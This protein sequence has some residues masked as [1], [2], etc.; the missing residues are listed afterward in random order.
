MNFEHPPP[1]M[2]SPR[3]VAPS[4]TNTSASNATSMSVSDLVFAVESGQFDLNYTT[5]MG[6]TLFCRVCLN[7]NHKP[8]WSQQF[9]NISTFIWTRKTVF[10]Y[11]RNQQKGR[12]EQPRQNN[13][14]CQYR[15]NGSQSRNRSPST[16]Q[17]VTTSTDASYNKM[18]NNSYAVRSGSPQSSQT[19][20]KI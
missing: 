12:N 2:S 8:S 18:K 17:C 1:Q 20:S 10:A 6:S 15:R 3:H 4:S 11:W 14:Y 7:D 9:K 16:N 13:N 19:S 5:S